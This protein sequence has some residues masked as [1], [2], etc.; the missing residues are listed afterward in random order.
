MILNHV[1]EGEGRRVLLLHP[2]GLD[3]TF[4]QPLCDRLSGRFRVM[5]IDLRGHGRSPVTPPA[6]GLEQFAEDVHETLK[7]HDFAPCAVVGFSFG[8]MVAQTLA[9][10]HPGDVDALVP[11]ACPAALTDENRRVAQARAADA[12]RG[13]MAAVV[14]ATLD[15]WFTPAFR[16]AGKDSAARERL[17]SDDPRGWAQGW[18][19]IA[20]IDN[21]PLLHG[22][23]VPALCIAGELDKSSPPHIVGAIARAI[24]GAQFKVVEGAP[25]MLFIEQPDAVARELLSFLGDG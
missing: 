1:V 14:E 22:I 13:G 4:L 12:E 2:V 25:H 18:R 6:D 17:L 23:G 7:Q 21:L 16:G 5:R 11:C 19:A 3:L 9:L 10:R 15:R 8:G 20:R 24:P